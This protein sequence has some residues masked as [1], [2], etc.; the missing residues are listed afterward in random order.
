[1]FYRVEVTDNLFG[2]YSVSREWGKCGRQGKQLLM[3][4]S[5]IRDACL[6]ADKWRLGAKRRGYESKGALQ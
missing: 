4:F 2:E 1:M 3:W 5:N 6:A